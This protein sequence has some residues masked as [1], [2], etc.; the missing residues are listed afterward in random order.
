MRSYIGLGLIWIAAIYL[1]LAQPFLPGWAWGILVA[2]AFLYLGKRTGGPGLTESGLLLLGWAVGAMLA[3]A[4]G[5]Y[6]LK[7]VGVGAGV[8]AIGNMHGRTEIVYLGGALVLIGVLQGL[9]E[10]GAAPWA[11]LALIALGVWL[12]WQERGQRREE[13]LRRWR[14]EVAE[15]EGK[16][17][18]E[19]VSDEELDR[20]ARARSKEEIKEILGEERANYVEELAA[21]LFEAKRVP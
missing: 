4:T 15:R 14:R 9:F 13:K 11:A 17:E 18:R 8:W 7:V 21:L 3:E 1:A 5:L 16:D 2:A 6:A 10:V 20:L 12:L 19:V